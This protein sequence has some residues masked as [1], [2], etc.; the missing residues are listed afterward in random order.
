M[1]KTEYE[2]SAHF[3]YAT[4]RGSRC[5]VITTALLVSTLGAGSAATAQTQV[6]P[7][8]S[9]A[10]VQVLAHPSRAHASQADVVAASLAPHRSQRAPAGLAADP[11]ARWIEWPQEVAQDVD[12][13]RYV[14]PFTVNRGPI[15]TAEVR[16]RAI[17]GTAD[18]PTSLEL[19]LNDASIS[20][21]ALSTTDAGAF[22]TGDVASLLTPGVNRLSMG[23][24]GGG[25][26][27]RLMFSGR[28]TIRH[29]TDRAEPANSP[30][31]KPPVEIA[32]SVAGLGL[33]PCV[34]FT[35]RSRGDLDS[36]RHVDIPDY[37]LFVACFSGADAAPPD[38]CAYADFD[39]NGAVDL[40]DAAFFQSAFTGSW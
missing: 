38:G 1:A 22:V 19:R 2:M 32:G 29:A 16:W 35:C 14:I 13:V 3:A 23:L 5:A 21:V 17:G 39:C 6:I 25:G 10:G 26:M 18:G 24:P 9:D 15:D 11:T 36:D 30:S 37:E 31:G 12:A 7:F 27:P 33:D 28:V 40:V 20:E 34:G 4:R 8:R